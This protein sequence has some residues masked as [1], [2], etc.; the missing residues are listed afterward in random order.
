MK[1]GGHMGDSRAIKTSFSSDLKKGGQNEL[2]PARMENF[3]METQADVYF[4]FSRQP[5]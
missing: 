4:L 5:F 3:S 2:K 1:G